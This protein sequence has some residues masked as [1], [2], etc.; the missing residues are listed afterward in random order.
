LGPKIKTRD[1]AYVR[2]EWD[3]NH[4]ETFT[5][6]REHSFDVLKYSA[7]PMFFPDVLDELESISPVA[8]AVNEMGRAEVT[9]ALLDHL[10]G[11]QDP[12]GN[13]SMVLG[14]WHSATYDEVRR[15]QEE[16]KAEQT[17]AIEQSWTTRIPLIGGPLR[18]H[19][20]KGLEMEHERK[21]YRLDRLEQN[22]VM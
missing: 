15:V 21:T 1:L 14:L 22:L 4:I 19:N 5:F 8:D 10:S 18:D 6:Q 12:K 3:E 2:N 13:T 7:E 17:K 11:Y 16:H 20:L 9:Y